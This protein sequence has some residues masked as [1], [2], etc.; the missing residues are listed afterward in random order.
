MSMKEAK[1]IKIPRL[2]KL[3]LV[4]I[5]VVV[6]FVLNN[7][8]TLFF[9]DSLSLFNNKIANIILYPFKKLSC[10]IRGGSYVHSWLYDN[11]MCLSKLDTDGALERDLDGDYLDPVAAKPVIYLYPDRK[12]QVHI[13]LKYDPGFSVT[14]PDY[15]KGWDVT[16]EPSGKIINN[17]GKEY[18]YLYWEGNPDPDA[19]YDL[20]TGFVV[21]GEDTAS[22]LQNKLSEF[23]LMPKEYNEFIVYWLAKMEKNPYNLIHFASQSEYSD[24]AILEITPKPDSILR[25]FMVYKPIIKPINVQ[26][27][28]ITEF[29]RQGFTVVEWGGSELH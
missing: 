13:E 19:S 10:E 3:V 7:F 5:V 12:M 1:K 23:G 6:V 21:K 4:V 16:A 18:G 15:K 28:I 2:L 22:F 20:S 14:Y 27:Q 24:K 8:L 17:D 26:P 11:Y 29:Q 25:V 9:G